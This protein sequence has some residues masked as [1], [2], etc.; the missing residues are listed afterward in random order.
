MA[1]LLVLYNTVK[2]VIY[3]HCFG[4]PPDLCDQLKSQNVMQFL[5]F[6]D[7]FTPLL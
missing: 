1:G 5:R 3:G 6:D 7:Y 4:R 2:P